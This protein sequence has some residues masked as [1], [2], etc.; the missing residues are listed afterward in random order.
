VV[1][2]E[3]HD[4]GDTDAAL[5]PP[6]AADEAPA[7][8]PAPPCHADGGRCFCQDVKNPAAAAVLRCV[9]FDEDKFTQDAA[10]AI[11]VTLFA[12]GLGTV[13][14]DLLAP[15]S[16]PRA[17][18]ID[19]PWKGNEDN[20][21]GQFQ[22]F[23]VGDAGPTDVLLEFSVA[24]DETDAAGTRDA[25]DDGGPLD[26]A[27]PLILIELHPDEPKGVLFGVGNG[28]FQLAKVENAR[29][30]EKEDVLATAAPLAD[31]PRGFLR[32]TLSLG[33]SDCVSAVPPEDGGAPDADDR[34]LVAQVRVPNDDPEV[35]GTLINCIRLGHPRLGTEFRA[36]MGAG[37]AHPYKPVRVRFDDIVARKKAFD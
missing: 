26:R 25:S 4:G 32:A 17:L 30:P 8:P 27:Y 20:A 22:A 6:D 24:F 1:S 7:P 13:S 11:G 35:R 14:Y 5:A 12:G 36:Y 34:E 33:F 10:A 21:A 9:D 31:I 2:L 29:D 16:P 15:E 37:V 19:I 3:A 28:K 18:Q 23:Y